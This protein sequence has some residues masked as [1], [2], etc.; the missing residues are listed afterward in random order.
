MYIV[1]NSAIVGLVLGSV[2]SYQNPLVV[3]V[4]KYVCIAFW[5]QIYFSS[6]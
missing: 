6:T 3:F 1:V 2:M 4:C 5:K